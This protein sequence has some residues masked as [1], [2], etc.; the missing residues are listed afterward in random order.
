[1]RKFYYLLSA[2]TILG[3]AAWI[4]FDQNEPARRSKVP[5]QMRIDGAI[6]DRLITSSDDDLG[7][8][9]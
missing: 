3:I 9:P 8:I 5:K 2:L 6:A 1:M 4:S 7:I